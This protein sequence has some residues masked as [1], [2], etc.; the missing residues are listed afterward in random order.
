MHEL[1]VTE[2]ILDIAKRH[3]VKANAA[4]VTSIHLVMGQLSSILDD[5]VQFYWDMI[6]KE[7]LCAGAQLNFTRI[8]AEFKCNACGTQFKLEGQLT[9]CPNCQGTQIKIIAGTEFFVE[10]IEIEPRSKT[11][12]HPHPHR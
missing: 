5:S 4:R 10:S 2:S 12:V 6:S 9:C 8:P 7:T 3:A 1:A 11:D